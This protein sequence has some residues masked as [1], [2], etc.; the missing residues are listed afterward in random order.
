MSGGGARFPK[1]ARLRKRPEFLSLSQGGRKVH[2]SHFVVISK[3]NEREENR[4]GI[5]VSARVGNAVVRNRIKRLLREFFRRY[6]H[7]IAP[8]QDILVIAKRGAENLSLPDVA[9]EIRK[10]VIPRNK[11]SP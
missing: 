2:T 8:N 6:R 10:G 3:A 1:Q 11:R 9:H 7:E 5:T 4:L